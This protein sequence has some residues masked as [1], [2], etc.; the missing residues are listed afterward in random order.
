VLAGTEADATQ[1]C[2]NAIHRNFD[3]ACRKSADVAFLDIAFRF[4]YQIRPI[5]R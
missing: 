4:W 2:T 5:K 3:I 1:T